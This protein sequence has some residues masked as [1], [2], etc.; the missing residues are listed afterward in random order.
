MRI[1]S[2]GGE[3]L[4]KKEYSNPLQYSCLEN[5]MERGAWRVTTHG[6]AK[7]LDTT[8]WLKHNKQQLHLQV[9]HPELSQK[10]NLI[11]FLIPSSNLF[12]FQFTF[13][14]SIIALQCCVNFWYTTTWVSYKYTHIPYILRL[15]YPTAIHPNPLGHHRAPSWAPCVT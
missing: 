11:A 4:L 14:W 13:N 7:E 15:P 2:L 6:V 9:C 8:L 12:S 5:P 3:D 10:S 1:W